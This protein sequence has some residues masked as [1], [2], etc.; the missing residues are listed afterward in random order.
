MT[1]PSIAE[2][3]SSSVPPLD[4]PIA[5]SIGRFAE[6]FTYD[7]IPAAVRARACDLMLD[8][9]GVAFASSTMPFARTVRDGVH[10]LGGAAECAVIG[11]AGRLPLRDAVLL[12]GMLIHGLDYDDTHLDGAVHP[13]ASALPCALA[14]S[15]RVDAS[16]RDLLAAYVLGVETVTRVSMA[17]RF[18]FHHHGFHPTG[19]S[20][21]FSCSVQAGWLLGLDAHQLAMAQGI[22]GST[23]AASQEFLSEGAW[24]KRMHPGWAGVAGI[25]AAYLAQ[26][27]FIGPTRPYEGRFGL[28]KSHLHERESEVDYDAMISGLGQRWELVPTAVK[29]YPICHFIHAPA[30]AALALARAHDV[31]PDD[32]ARIRVRLPPGGIP[33]VAEPADRKLAPQSSYDAQFS[34]PFVI[35]ACLVLRRFGLPELEENVRRDGRILELAR[36]VTCEPDPETRFPKYYSGGVVIDMRD[37]RTLTHHEPVNRGAGDRALTSD[38]IADKFL[39]NARMCMSPAQARR[40]RDVVVDVE[41]FRAREVAHLLAT[42][43]TPR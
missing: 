6:R 3:S 4:T 42:A 13:T 37:G 23:A 24:N 15:E 29:P 40:V 38:E 34:A 35:A 1:T 7:D 28:F 20:A 9:L 41:R 16:G 10:A 8:A 32:I 33:I 30:D 25:T 21:H 27:G 17:S 12:N 5:L 14:M 36:K 26:N 19:I 11:D 43:A 39:A 18:G 22:T 2:R 31:A